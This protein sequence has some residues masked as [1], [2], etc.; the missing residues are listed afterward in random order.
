MSDKKKPKEISGWYIK[1][2]VTADERQHIEDW[3]NKR[4]TLNYRTI[5]VEAPGKMILA[6]GEL[7]RQ[8]GM[9]GPRFSD[10]IEGIL[11]EYLQT[12]GINWRDR[13]R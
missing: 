5:P 12:Q 13:V 9:D 8:K 11:D 4:V 2:R 1:G 7:A 3:Y 10:F 6:L